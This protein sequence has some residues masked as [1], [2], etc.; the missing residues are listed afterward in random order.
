MDLKQI[1]YFLAIVTAGSFTAAAD[2]LYVSQSSLS[3]QI[4]ALEKELD[5]VLFD[6]DQ[7]RIKLTP[8]GEAFLPHARRVHDAYD[9]ML[10][11]LADAKG[12]APAFA[13]AAIPVI[14]QYR[15]T[16]AIVRFRAA[17]PDISFTLEE[18]EAAV[19]APGMESHRYDLAIMR[20]N[21]LD[22]ALYTS[23]PITR[24]RFVLAVAAT[25]PLALRA[26]VALAELAGLP[27][28]MFDRGTIV[29][30]LADDACR[31]AGFTPTAVYSSTRVESVLGMVAASSG[32]A[33]IM[34][35]VVAYHEHAGVVVVPLAEQIES[36]VV[37]AHPKRRRLSQSART[38]VDFVAAHSGEGMSPAGNRQQSLPVDET[39]F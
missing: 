19:I 32:V 25:H 5:A 37:I 21:F 20:S 11:T 8:L 13:V 15:V 16:S 26:E 29:R 33:L 1:T 14:A 39:A 12:L 23:I 35:Q 27:F 7:R 24:D 36:T 34:E 22:D 28:V 4:R 3:K 30:E 10:V 31:A 2:E 18:R 6:R 9:A 17:F 38:F